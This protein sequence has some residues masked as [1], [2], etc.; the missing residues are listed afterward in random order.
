[1]QPDREMK[2][3]AT[4]AKWREWNLKNPKAHARDSAK[5][6]LRTI[7]DGNTPSL[8]GHADFLT[9]IIWET[10]RGC[11]L[12]AAQ[13]VDDELKQ[14]LTNFF[15]SR[16]SIGKKELD[17]WFDSGP[18]PPLRSTG[19]KIRLALATELIGREIFNALNNLQSLRSN[20]AAHARGL[21]EISLDDCVKIMKHLPEPNREEIKEMMATEDVAQLAKGFPETLS[22]AKTFFAVVFMYLVEMLRTYRIES[23]GSSL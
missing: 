4:I 20:V 11:V 15:K 23:N 3:K 18:T 16:S 2:A 10:D 22:L 9:S 8:G 12:V 17:F 21:F 5:R 13:I 19:L 1:M 7:W 6:L 14:L